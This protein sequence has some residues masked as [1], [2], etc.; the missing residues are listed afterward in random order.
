LNSSQSAPRAPGILA[1]EEELAR[2][3]GLIDAAAGGSGG[4][5][6]VE[7]AAGIGKTRLL[8]EICR[9]GAD[10]GLCVLSARASELER[11]FA[12]GLVRQAVEPVLEDLDA[13]GRARLLA[14]VVR[15]AAPVLSGDSAPDGEPRPEPYAVLHGLFWLLARLADQRPVLLALDDLHWADQGTLDLLSFVVPRVESVPL[16][17]IGAARPRTDEPADAQLAML[18][19]EPGVTVLRPRSLDE[20]AVGTLVADVLGGD[21]DRQFVLAC[22]AASGGNPFLLIELLRELRERRLKPAAR[23]AHLVAL[24][25]PENVSR[26]V[27]GR[28]AS[29]GGAALAVARAV[30][31]LGE[32]PTLALAAEMAG[33]DERAAVSAATALTRAGVFSP[34]APVGFAHPL[35]RTA[36]DSELAPA[37][38]ARLHQTAARLLEASGAGVELTGLHLAETEPRGD[39]HA[40]RILAEAG[41]GALRR[42]APETAARLLRRAL[43]ER[44]RDE[45]RCRLLFDLG[46]A[47]SELGGPE[48][49]D[50]LEQCVVESPDVM[51]QTKALALLDLAWI[52]GPR[53]EAQHQLLPLY[54]RVTEEAWQRDRQLALSLEAARLSVL[55]INPQLS[56]QFEQQ[57]DRFSDLA[58]DT[59]AECALLAW[60]ARRSLMAGGPAGVVAELA[61]RAARHPDVN[62]ASAAWFLHMVFSLISAERL[63]TAERVV[64]RALEAATDRGSVSGFASCS[65]L[66]GLVR[67]AAGDLRGCEADAR[68]ALDSGGLAGFYPFQPLIPLGESLADQGR[69]TEVEALLAQRQLDGELP[70]ARPYTALLIARG[71]LRAAAGDMP[72][73]SRDLRQAL[74]RLDQA[75]SRGVVGI[76]GRL[77]AALVLHALGEVDQARDLSDQALELAAKWEGRRAQGGALRVAGLLRGGENGLEMLREAADTLEDSPARLWHAKALVDLGATLRRANHRRDC[78]EPLREGIE[79]AERCGAIPLADRARRELQASGG[80][81]PPRTGGGHDT[82]TPSELR[83]AEL[84]ASGLSNPEIAQRLFVT[85]KTVEMHL[86]N[87]YRKLDISSRHQLAA[88]LKRI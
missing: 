20:H 37:D 68:A 9:K 16:I 47:E 5:L 63:Q 58:G 55:F 88:A 51:I 72:A 30:A 42:G 28:I 71:R 6:L 29:L 80:R 53:P 25:S 26:S 4:V 10:A 22:L 19:A 14:G 11:S 7:G 65:T 31:V 81:V 61:E 44:P 1:R 13:A 46:S 8:R 45:D 49:K 78:R 33:L 24:V 3:G 69:S 57:A 76:D 43:D 85:I 74:H 66:R 52:T 48:A 77:E 41:R 56:A 83:I 2:A 12:F 32:H 87:A 39:E 17:V 15:P 79:L 82:L 70:D 54:E 60:V 34:D 38:R 64:T 36:V 86:S 75:G 84:A 23:N 18:T 50:H 59:P 62:A 35:L 40:L 27:A 21:P 73:A 67:H